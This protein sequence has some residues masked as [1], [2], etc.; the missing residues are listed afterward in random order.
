MAWLSIGNG[1]NLREKLKMRLH[2]AAVPPHSAERLRLSGN[3][4]LKFGRLRLFPRRSLENKKNL[5]AGKAEPFRTVRRQSRS[6]EVFVF[7]SS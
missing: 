4:Y 5:H 2:L 1:L 7:E 3:G 6:A